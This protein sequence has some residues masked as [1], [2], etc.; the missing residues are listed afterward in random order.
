M[1]RGQPGNHHDRE[2]VD[3]VRIDPPPLSV[4]ERIPMANPN[5]IT[6]RRA[7]NE[8]KRERLSHILNDVEA[9]ITRAKAL[10]ENDDPG[11]VL[12]A[13]NCVG[14]L[15]ISYTRV[16]EVGEIEQRLEALE[17]AAAK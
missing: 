7:R 16:Y 5:P 15:A 3:P 12:R 9:A 13:A 17:E 11:I 10:L 8:Q 14:Q 6:A 2:L 4:T 1:A